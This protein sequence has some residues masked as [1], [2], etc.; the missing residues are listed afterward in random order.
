MGGCI[1]SN[2]AKNRNRLVHA[3][4][5]RN[6]VIEMRPTSGLLYGERP[7]LRIGATAPSASHAP[8]EEQRQAPSPAEAP[9]VL[10]CAFERGVRSADAAPAHGESETFVGKSPRGWQFSQQTAVVE[11]PAQMR[12]RGDRVEILR[13]RVAGLAASAPELADELLDPSH[14]PA[15]ATVGG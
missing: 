3:R 8:L 7:A 15:E 1:L 2:D 11:A 14:W 10:L 9:R 6:M 4:V 12:R 5:A 13:E